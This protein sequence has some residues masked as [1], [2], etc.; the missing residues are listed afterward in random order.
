MLL[1]QGEAGKLSLIWVFE[2]QY[3]LASLGRIATES[4]LRIR[5]Y[6]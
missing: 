4:R 6:I 2:L 1:K 5:K 3:G